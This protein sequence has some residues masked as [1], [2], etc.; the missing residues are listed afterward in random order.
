MPHRGRLNLVTGLLEHPA[1][2]LFHKIKGYSEV[3]EE[4]GATG[5]VVS[6]VCPSLHILLSRTTHLM[7]FFSRLSKPHLRRREQ[8]RQGIHAPE[9]LPL[10]SHQPRRA[11]KDACKAVRTVEVPLSRLLP[12]RQGDVLA[13]ARRCELHWPRRGYGRI[14]SQYVTCFVIC[15][16]ELSLTL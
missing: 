5:D 11:R 13:A 8:S 10:R 9:S 4:L 1:R 6:H 2:A 14:G 16:P 3:P 7:P 15:P 12:R